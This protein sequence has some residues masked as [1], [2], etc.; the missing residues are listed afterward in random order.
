MSDQE[1]G[2]KDAHEAMP[3]CGDAEVFKWIS[4]YLS[5]EVPDMDY[6]G[7]NTVDYD[8]HSIIAVDGNYMMHQ[9]YIDPYSSPGWSQGM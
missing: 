3:L 5:D 2:W 8:N 7:I 9:K 4:A 6:D 1:N